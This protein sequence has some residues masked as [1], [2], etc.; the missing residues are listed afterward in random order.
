MRQDIAQSPGDFGSILPKQADDELT[1]LLAVG[2]DAPGDVQVV[3]A[4][5]TP[6]EPAPL[7]DSD[8]ALL[9]FRALTDAPDRHALPGVQAKASATMLTS[10]FTTMA[11]RARL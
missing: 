2:A 10:P 6:A 8:P 11:E 1:L 9:D 5:S 7:A 4:G 3:P